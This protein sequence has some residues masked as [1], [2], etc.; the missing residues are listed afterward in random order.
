MEPEQL[1]S[2]FRANGYLDGAEVTDCTMTEFETDGL[3]ARFYRA[4]LSYS[5][6]DHTLPERMVVKRPVLT[7]RGQGEANVYEGLLRGTVGLPLMACYGIV[8]E[9]PDAPLAFFFA[10]LSES[11]GQSKWPVVPALA[12]CRQAVATLA[13]VHAHWWGRAADI[14]IGEPPIARHEDPDH[15]ATFFG[16]F[17]DLVGEYLSRDK[18]E[19][20]ERLLAQVGPLVANRLEAG[21]ATLRH[22]DSHFWNFLYPN[23]PS[24][25]H[26]VIFD[27]PLWTTGLAAADLAYMIA[28]HLYPEHRERFEAELIG[29]YAQ[30]LGERGVNHSSDDV[31]L[32]YRIG[33]VVGLLMPIMEFSWEIPPS[34]WM[35]KM[36]KAFGAFN[37]L[38]CRELLDG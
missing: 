31:W 37:D 12:H 34:D 38:D 16:G 33:V 19:T 25:D 9:A 23:D 10:D 8:D 22:T 35:P 4:R 29:E 36:E 32:D 21:Y 1:T 24:T 7:D 26:C 30:A 5:S 3:G 6:P 15:L 27:W 18:R 2:V 17:V 20:Y 11:H 14:D 13:Q 28:L